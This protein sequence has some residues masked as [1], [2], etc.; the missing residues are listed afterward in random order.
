MIK[1]TKPPNDIESLVQTGKDLGIF[2]DPEG[3][4]LLRYL[5]G[6]IIDDF[7]VERTRRRVERAERQCRERNCPFLPAQMDR[8][9]FLFG[10]DEYQHLLWTFIQYLNAHTLIVAGTG[11]GK[12]T[13][14]KFQAIQ[15]ALHVLGMWL[16]DLRKREYRALRSLFARMG[17]DLKI[18]RGRQFRINP[19]QVPRG[20]DSMEYAAVAADFL[21]RVFNL[22][23][24]ASTL[25][26]S[27]I[28][29]L[30][31]ECGV[32]HGGDRYPTLFHLFETVRADHSANPQ[33][34]QAVLDN[35][36][37][38][39]LALGP[40]VLGYH[41]GWDVHELAR[42]HLDIEL[43]GLPDAGKELILNCLLTA[44]FISR[45]ARGISNPQMDLF[46][47]F[48]E[49]Q[50]LFSQKRESDSY[51]GNALVDLTGLVRG[52]G[53]GLEISVLTTHDLSATIPSL[54]ATK[55]MGRCGSVAEYQTAG[56]FLGLNSEQTMWCA[57]HLV[58]GQFVSQIGEGDWRYPFVFRVP[59]IGHGFVVPQGTSG[60]ETG[61]SVSKTAQNEGPQ[62]P[63]FCDMEVSVKKESMV[64]SDE[65]ADQS[66]E[67]L[68]TGAAVPASVQDGP[69]EI[70]TTTK[71]RA[72]D[73]GE[74]ALSEPALR[75]LRAIVDHPLRPS[76]E[77][78][79]LARI[80][81]NTLQKLRPALVG[82]G[83]IREHKLEAGGRRGRSTLMLEPLEAAR[84]LLSGS[85]EERIVNEAPDDA[86]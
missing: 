72:V 40:E 78:P 75:L 77:Y 28:I 59:Q 52:T 7:L 71:T 41:R 53:I 5:E 3:R 73:P 33:A 11:A 26:R 58:P 85:R 84:E 63:A 70:G 10:Y 17:I 35:F 29:K 8:G 32:L 80:S 54:T 25:L 42:Q 83:L 4:T 18:I 27:T 66:L 57:H 21:V 37:A 81:P 13:L 24:R 65:E 47:A 55:I 51:G 36:E 56:R 86:R 22:P 74:G 1:E 44:E 39:L 15:I 38:V 30:Y 45:V 49:G 19:L 60:A 82:R 34:R 76:S 50:R 16:V 69:Q 2:K 79:S 46:I 14:S 62:P 68:V 64:V 20:V 67:F 48:D 12:T 43:T 9:D 31:R 23:P 61:N 6:H